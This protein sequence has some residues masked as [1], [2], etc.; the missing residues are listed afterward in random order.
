[1]RTLSDFIAE[2]GDA[3]AAAMFG[4]KERTAASWRRLENYPRATK[5]QEIV[6][7]TGGE[8]TMAGIYGDK[9]AA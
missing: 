7:I 6:E 8:V 5:A 1:M 3:A 4:V 9:Q 2:K